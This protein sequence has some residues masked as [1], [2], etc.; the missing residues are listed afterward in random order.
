M[1]YPGMVLEL[2]EGQ[3]L[4]NKLRSSMLTQPLLIDLFEK[5]VDA[6]K[7]IWDSGY[8][9][10]DSHTGNYQVIPEDNSL[11]ILDFGYAYPIGVDPTT[12]LTNKT[13]DLGMFCRHFEFDLEAKLSGDGQLPG[14]DSILNKEYFMKA[15]DVTEVDWTGEENTRNIASFCGS[16]R[17]MC[18]KKG[19]VAVCSM[20]LMEAMLEAMPDMTETCGEF[21]D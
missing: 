20:A 13:R 6:L 12:A 16:R 10:A 8:T 18:R 3:S 1:R 9:H 15:L 5:G 19:V 2:L 4:K 7:V 11:V 21:D 17:K 14:D